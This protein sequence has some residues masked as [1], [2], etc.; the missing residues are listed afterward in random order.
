MH[1]HGLD[2]QIAQCRHA[3]CGYRCCD[4]SGGNYIALYPGELNDAVASGASL[5]H[6]EVRPSADGGCRAICHADDKATCDGGYKPLDCA[7][8]PLF[9]TIAPDGRV[10]AG[11]KGRKCPLIAATIPRHVQWVKAA[12]TRLAEASPAVRDWIARVRLVG[13]RESNHD[14]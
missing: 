9:P 13:Y 6:L 1:G 10:E 2:G 14:C 3:A 7:S 5:D 8:Y 11:L 12:W 4:F